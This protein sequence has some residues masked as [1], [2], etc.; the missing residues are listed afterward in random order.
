[1]NLADLRLNYTRDSLNEDAMPND[2]LVLFDAWL[3]EVI[4]SEMPDPNAM[5]LATVDANHQPSQRIVLLK[6]RPNDQFV[7]F[8]NY[9][10]N[11]AKDVQSNA[12]VSLHFPW[13]AL[14]RQVMVL[15]NIS[16]ISDQENDA[17]FGSRP[18]QSQVGAYVSKQSQVLS[19]KEEL[20]DAYQAMLA[21]YTDKYVPRPNWGGYVVSP[22]T[23]EFW[24]GGSARL[25]D[26]IRYTREHAN[27]SWQFVRLN[28]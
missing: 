15:G 28:P 2:P 6:G 5:T 20:V 7:F 24:Q 4:E 26:R 19:S 14:E 18:K 23:I 8:T 17:Y 12:K 10:S 16:K 13:Y 25:H 9:E 21:E 1:M 27:V 11:K 22:H 3:K